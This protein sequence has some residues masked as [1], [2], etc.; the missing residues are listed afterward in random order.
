[1]AVRGARSAS[2]SKPGIEAKSIVQEDRRMIEGKLVTLGALCN[3][4]GGEIS[5]SIDQMG[6]IARLK[7]DEW[8]RDGLPTIHLPDYMKRAPRKKT[9]EC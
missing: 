4:E 3:F 5:K 8:I 6:L 9:E 2:M 1:M 7:F